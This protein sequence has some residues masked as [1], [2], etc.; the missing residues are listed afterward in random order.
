MIIATANIQNTAP[1][2]LPVNSETLKTSDITEQPV[3]DLLVTQKRNCFEKSVDA[4]GQY[5]TILSNQISKNV[6]DAMNTSDN[7]RTDKQEVI[8]K[9]SY[10]SRVKP[11]EDDEPHSRHKCQKLRN[12]SCRDKSQIRE[13]KGKGSK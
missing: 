6:I 11:S 5:M 8:K 7:P 3:Q 13:K 4:L 12:N 10:S 2:S 9:R 1:K